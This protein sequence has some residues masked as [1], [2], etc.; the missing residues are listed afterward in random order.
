MVKKKNA[1]F[2]LD[3]TRSAFSILTVI[4]LQSVSYKASFQQTVFIK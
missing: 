4:L 3:K 2:V 1:A